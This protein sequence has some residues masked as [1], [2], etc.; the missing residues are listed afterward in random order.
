MDSDRR[1][2][3]QLLATTAHDPRAFAAFYVRHEDRVRA[4]M[5][6][7]TGRA[8]LAADLCAEVFAAALSLAHRFR[9]SG[10]PAEAWLFGIAR[11]V[12]GTSLR[13]GRVEARA[14]QRLRMA[15][16]ELNDEVLERIDEL[17]H[18]GTVLAALEA[19]SDDQ[20]DA[21]RARVVEERDYAD[22]AR[23]LRCSQE[24]V[25]KRVSRGLAV[26]RVRVEAER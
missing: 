21:V 17:R 13:R 4:W 6:R 14:R 3:A 18:D 16:I 9:G 10:P 5:L 1:T 22:I 25:R 11:N 19:L 12:L 8:D 7:R 26:L 23:E 20:R 2:D 15:P 24:V